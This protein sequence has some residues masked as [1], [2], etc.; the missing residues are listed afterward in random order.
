MHA[1]DIE[2]WG[3]ATNA[4]LAPPDRTQL[5]IPKAELLSQLAAIDRKLKAR[6]K[7][8][9]LE[10]LV[11]LQ[12]LNRVWRRYLT[13]QQI[14][15]AFYVLDRSIGW[16]NSIM[17][18]SSANVLHGN[19]EYSGVGMPERTYFRTLTELERI[20][21]LYRKSRRDRTVLGL[22]LDWQPWS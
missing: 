9:P 16:G 5:P 3:W 7:P 20:G 18:A 14:S 10:K 4:E 15:V 1:H 13:P 12:Y 11:V 22:H 2:E 17:L 19:A 6:T 21:L 8:T